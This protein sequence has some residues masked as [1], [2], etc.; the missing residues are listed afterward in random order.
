MTIEATDTSF[1]KTF[2]FTDY[3]V[4]L[5]NS[6]IEFEKNGNKYPVSS[7]FQNTYDEE[8][9]F[10]VVKNIYMRFECVFPH[11][12]RQMFDFIGRGFQIFE[13]Q[14]WNKK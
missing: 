3:K 14:D 7:N 8:T 13:N 4:T 5:R 10:V 9:G 12:L 6:G 1:Q 2:D 11:Q